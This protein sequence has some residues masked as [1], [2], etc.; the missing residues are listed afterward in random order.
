MKILLITLFS[1][2]YL[3]AQEFI[4]KEWQIDNF[5]GEYPDVTDVYFL[6]TAEDNNTFGK[7]ILFTPEGT[8]TS[9]LVAERNNTCASPTIGTYQK[10]D[11]NYLTIQVDKMEKHGV[12]CDSIPTILNLNLGSYYFYKISDD[13]CY[14]VKSTGKLATDKQKLKDVAALVRF[15]NVDGLHIKSPNPSFQLKNDVPKDA[16]I[17]KLAQ[18]LFHLT[19]YQIL[20][21]YPNDFSTLYLVKD[22]KNNTYCYFR[23]EYRAGKVIAY[24]YTEKDIKKLIKEKKKQR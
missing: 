13:E 10:I 17:G 11:K 21:G 23:E 7:R 20:K 1:I 16:R 19:G 18:K 4:G 24:Y 2:T 14:L 22:L 3:S 15:Y 12:E 9:W 8:F 6:K 5:L